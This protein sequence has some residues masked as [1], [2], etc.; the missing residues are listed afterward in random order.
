MYERLRELL[1][2]DPLT[3]VFTWLVCKATWIR[4]GD[5][6]GTPDKDGYTVITIDGK[7]MRA[8]RLAWLYMTGGWP[9][10]EID[11]KDTCK[12]NDIWT[13]LREATHNQNQHNQSK[14]INNTS[15]YKGV[16][17]HKRDQCWAVVIRINGKAKWLGN[18]DTPKLAHAAYSDAAS[19]YHKEF[20]RAA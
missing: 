8:A 20:A 1:H 13:N 19:Q 14:P 18:F 4:I 12:S 16:H 7:K 5:V 17:W 3:G 6:A 15:G 9:Q 11:H 2:Y 10:H